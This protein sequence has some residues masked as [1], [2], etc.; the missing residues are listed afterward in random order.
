VKLGLGAGS[1]ITPDFA[2]FDLLPVSQSP[3]DFFANL[4]SANTAITFNGAD[5][6]LNGGA[7]AYLSTMVA[8]GVSRNTAPIRKV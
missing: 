2:Y 6:P 5:L 3:F 7:G 8:G 1:L 4:W